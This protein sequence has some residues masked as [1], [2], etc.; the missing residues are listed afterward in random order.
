MS[1]LDKND[2]PLS[3]TFQ[4]MLA[5][6]L[7]LFVILKDIIVGAMVSAEPK[8]IAGAFG[9]K[10]SQVLPVHLYQYTVLSSPMTYMLF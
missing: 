1:T 2:P 6:V 9:P 7:V 8:Q 10:G 3:A 4:V 5:L